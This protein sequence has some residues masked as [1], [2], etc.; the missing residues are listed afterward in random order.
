MTSFFGFCVTC[1]FQNMVGTLLPLRHIYGPN[2]LIIMLWSLCTSYYIFYYVQIVRQRPISVQ[3]AF[4]RVM[5]AE[6]EQASC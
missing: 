4:H 3:F 1:Y 6:H 5:F 2:N